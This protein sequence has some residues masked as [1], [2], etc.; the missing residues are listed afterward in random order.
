[1]K[2]IKKFESYSTN[3]EVNLKNI[4]LGAVMALATACSNGY[5]E[6]TESDNY[7]GD[8]KVNRIQMGGSRDN[9]FNVYG[10][11][12]QGKEVE[13]STDNLTFNVGDSIH[14]DFEKEEAY[15]L[16]DKE[17]VAPFGDRGRIEKQPIFNGGGIK[18]ANSP[19]R[20]FD[21]KK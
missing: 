15:P 4:A 6:G 7:T 12:S 19:S 16:K 9:T 11:D 1:M 5:V 8:L 20:Y 21:E 17:N 14:V 13:F 10:K 2:H 3:E 18:P